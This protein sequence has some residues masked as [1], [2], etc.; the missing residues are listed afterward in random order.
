VPHQTLRRLFY[1]R[2]CG[3]EEEMYLSHLLLCVLFL[4]IFLLRFSTGVFNAAV[5]ILRRSGVMCIMLPDARAQV[6]M[7]HKKPDKCDLP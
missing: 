3:Q 2:A 7:E 5:I 1:P 6:C 4:I